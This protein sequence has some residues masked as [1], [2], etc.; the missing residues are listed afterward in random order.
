MEGTASP[1]SWP[2]GLELQRCCEEG[3][4]S[5][6]S[7]GVGR[8]ETGVSQ[9]RRANRLAWPAAGRLGRGGRAAQQSRP[10]KPGAS[11]K[12]FCPQLPPCCGLRACP[13]AVC[14]LPCS[15]RLQRPRVHGHV[16]SGK[17]PAGLG[18]AGSPGKPAAWTLGMGEGSGMGGRP[19][20]A[21][22]G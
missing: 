2:G 21:A 22:G 9:G 13:G 5:A 4:G 14:H 6:S 17:G 18:S 8:P 19:G 11:R 10:L 16:C 20:V 12:G 7:V 3:A 1:L 15:P